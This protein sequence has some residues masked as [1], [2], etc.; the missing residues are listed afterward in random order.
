[1]TTMLATLPLGFHDLVAEVM[2]GKPF[3]RNKLPQTTEQI[4]DNLSYFLP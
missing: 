2:K 3:S 4:W 1:M